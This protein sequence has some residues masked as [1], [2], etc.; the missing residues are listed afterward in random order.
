MKAPLGATDA[1]LKALHPFSPIHRNP[2]LLTIAANFWRRPFDSRAYPVEAK[3]Y[4][5]APTVEVLVHEQRP[6]GP[7][8]GELILVHGLEGSS[9]AGYMRSMAFAALRAGYAVH[10]LNL[11]SCGGTEHLCDT[12][13]HAGLTDDV[14]TV[15][16]RLSNAGRGPVTL[17]G[18]SLGGNVVL[19]LAGELGENALLNGVAAVSTP[20]DLAECVKRLRHPSNRL[21][22]WRFVN[23]MKV[24]L[25]QRQQLMPGKFNFD[26]LDRIRT[27]YDL[28]HSITAPLFGFD[29][30]PHYY[31]T[32]S[33]RLFLDQIRVPAL[34]IQ[35]K[36]DPM[37]PFSVYDHPAF[38]SNPHLRL[39]A[40]DHGGH[41]GF[42]ASGRSRFWAD[43][44]ILD[45]MSA[46][47]NKS[48]AEFVSK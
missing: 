44:V 21:Y 14:R 23:R 22:E 30:A 29:G 13:Y 47:G 7:A 42:L 35:A 2:H 38:H 39:L 32:Q 1:K 48:P 41:L 19:K 25:R 31:A 10:R 11:R 26:M 46:L 27:V 3:L 12:L 16:E 28:D 24:R 43:G 33:S 45:W 6:Q 37:I 36:D 17:V 40:V 8:R 15:A 20:I 18:Y 9:D 5:T 34:I 4:R